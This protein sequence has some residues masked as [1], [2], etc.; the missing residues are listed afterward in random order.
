MCVRDIILISTIY[1]FPCKNNLFN[2]LK[3]YEKT[4]N[5]LTFSLFRNLIKEIQVLEK[6]RLK[7]LVDIF[8][9]QRPF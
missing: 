5:L 8:Q 3:D 2:Y 7:L 1:V 4:L 6:E 9:E